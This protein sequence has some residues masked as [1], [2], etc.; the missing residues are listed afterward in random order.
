VPLLAVLV[1]GFLLLTVHVPSYLLRA[2][3]D[4]HLGPQAD[5]SLYPRVVDYPWPN[6]RAHKEYGIALAEA[7]QDEEARQEL[8]KALKGLDTGDIYLAL[9]LLASEAG[10]RRA[11]LRWAT[12][13]LFRWPGNPDALRL[14][15]MQSPRGRANLRNEAST[16]REP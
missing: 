7:G 12:E 10:D 2:A 5:I 3:E 1:G 13:C 6:A 16:G 8:L 4:A 14:I 15:E 9:A 11:T